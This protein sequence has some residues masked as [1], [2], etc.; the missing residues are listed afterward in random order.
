MTHVVQSGS[1]VGAGWVKGWDRD[2]EAAAAAAA[3]AARRAS[4]FKIPWYMF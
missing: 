2:W 4:S 3:L 1:T